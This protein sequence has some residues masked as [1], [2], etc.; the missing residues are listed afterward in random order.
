[1]IALKMAWTYF[2][3]L[4]RFARAQKRKKRARKRRGHQP[5]DR[6]FVVREYKSAVEWI[7]GILRSMTR[8]VKDCRIWELTEQGA[9]AQ[10]PTVAQE[11]IVVFWK[12]N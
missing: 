4:G 6:Q 11:C 12:G 10:S 1:M 2:V 7:D 8:K 9:G 3:S 5:L